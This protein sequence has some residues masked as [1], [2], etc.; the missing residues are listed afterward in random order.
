MKT[1][2]SQNLLNGAFKFTH[3]AFDAFGNDFGNVLRHI[4]AGAFGFLQ[5]NLHAH[6]EFGGLNHDDQALRET[7]E[8]PI[9]EFG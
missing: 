1:R 8:Q 4:D 9:L 5:K 6:L 2:V 3:I 7:T